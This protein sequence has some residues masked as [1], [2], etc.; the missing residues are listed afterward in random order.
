MGPKGRIHTHNETKLETALGPNNHCIHCAEL[1]T[2]ERVWTWRWSWYFI[3]AC[4]SN[5]SH[6]TCRRLKQ[7]EKLNLAL[8]LTLCTHANVPVISKSV[9]HP[10]MKDII[11]LS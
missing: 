8:M 10:Q 11:Y 6:I 9:L 1:Y 5:Y 4:K 7:T 3:Y 2:V